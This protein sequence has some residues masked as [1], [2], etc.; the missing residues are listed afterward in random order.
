MNPTAA[1]F[2]FYLV[3]FYLLAAAMLFTA[4]GIYEPMHRKR[5]H[6]GLVQLMVILWPVYFVAYAIHITARLIHDARINHG[7]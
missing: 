4:T 5:V 1:I 6:M 3:S 7:T 2:L